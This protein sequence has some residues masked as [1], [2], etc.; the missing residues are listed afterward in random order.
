MWI[1]LQVILRIILAQI[2]ISLK[3]TLDPL[4]IDLILMRGIN[5]WSN[6]FYS[7]PF[8]CKDCY[9]WN[10]DH[11]LHF[12]LYWMS[13][14][15]SNLFISQGCMSVF[16]NSDKFPITNS[17]HVYLK[18][19]VNKHHTFIYNRIEMRSCL[20]IQSMHFRWWIHFTLAMFIACHLSFLAWLRVLLSSSRI[21]TLFFVFVTFSFILFYMWWRSL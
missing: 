5:L 16:K 15:V 13:I 20:L 12:V 9:I 4:R 1:N 17:L 19:D 7:C 3:F 8:I 6:W 21:M 18:I 10:S 11:S 14:F 2:K